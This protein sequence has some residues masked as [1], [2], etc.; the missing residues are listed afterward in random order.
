MAPP[1]RNIAT[2]IKARRTIHNFKPE[3]PAK[4]I[5]LQS[6]ELACW[7]PNHHLTE[8][9]HF[10]LLGKETI[11]QICELK[12]TLLTKQKDA[13]MPQYERWKKIPGWLVVTCQKSEDESRYREDYAACCCAIQNL[14]LLLWEQDIGTKWST[15]SIIH[16][17]RFYDAVWINETLETVVG[18]IWYGFAAEIPQTVRKSLR[19]VFTE[20]P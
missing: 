2:L 17:T 19:Q 1:K 9:W 15:G 5:I 12:R 13:N 10:Y 11:A 3:L 8:P 4:E 18:I 14:M 6:I 16:E 7:A 20:L